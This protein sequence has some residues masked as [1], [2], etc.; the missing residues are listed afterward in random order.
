MLLKYFVFCKWRFYCKNI[1]QTKN[2]MKVNVDVNVENHIS[3]MCARKFVY[4][5][6]VY[7]L[8][9]VCDKIYEVDEYSNNCIK[10]VADGSVITSEDKI[11]NDTTTMNTSLASKN[12]YYLFF[13]VFITNCSCCMNK[14]CTI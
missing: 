14:Y 6:L 4:G 1:V 3:N 7:V 12:L 11:L 8:L 9:S 13:I 5:I 2:G 10:H